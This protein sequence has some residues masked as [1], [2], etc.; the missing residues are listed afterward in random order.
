MEINSSGSMT[1]HLQLEIK[2]LPEKVSVCNQ[3]GY[4]GTQKGNV[5]RRLFCRR[6]IG[7]GVKGSREET[8]EL[9]KAK[10]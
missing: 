8:Q 10:Q 5:K 9:T 6:C 7:V 2:F 4:Y 3:L 1:L